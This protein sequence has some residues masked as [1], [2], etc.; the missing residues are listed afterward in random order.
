MGIFTSVDAA[1]VKAKLTER[2]AALWSATQPSSTEHQPFLNAT[3][4]EIVQHI[5][6][7]EWT[8][9]QVLEAYI[10]RAVQAQQETRCLTEVFLERA[11]A[12]AR[13]LDE[14]F[15]TS[16]TLRGPLHGVPV[17][18]KDQLHVAGCDTTLGYTTRIHRPEN[19][20]AVI[21]TLLRNAGAVPFVKTNIPQTLMVFECSNP[22]WGRSLNPWSADHT[23]GGSSGG[24]GA[25]LAMDGSVLGIGSDV[26]GSL[27]IPAH[28]CGIYS[29]KPGNIR[30]SSEGTTSTVPGFTAVTSAY[31]PMGRSVD[32]LETACRVL[33]GH[34][35]GHGAYFPAPVPFR[36]HWQKIPKKLRFG[37]YTS[38]YFIK[39][40]PA[41]KR[42]VLET[43]EALRSQGHECIDFRVPGAVR[44]LELFVALSSSDGYRTVLSDIGPDKRESALYLMTL[45]PRLPSFVR[46]FASW[47]SS[48]IDP[49]FA[50]LLALSRKK[51][52]EEYHQF[53]AAKHDFE[54]DW[55]KEVWDC[56]EFDAV[57]APVQA[58]PALPH[59]GC[60]YLSPLAAAT[61]LYNIVEAPVGCIPVTRVDPDKD[62][63]TD[64]WL[65]AP[66]RGS[67]I[68][69]SRVYGLGG[70]YDPV[71][72][73]GL[74]VGVQIVARP[75]E[76]EK[77]LGIMRLVDN[78][79]GPRG[80][81]PGC[82]KARD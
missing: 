10:A 42:A 38:D 79:L 66:D 32:D 36:D 55:R 68:L 40:S 3:A 46:F 71:K 45:G 62:A 17:S 51:S 15:S 54:Y 69:E 1:A 50:K 76:E 21:A 67:K 8:A 61:I 25:L 72:M 78:A 14:H 58:V 20:D 34:S 7:G 80:F 77:L 4:N 52:V 26:G 18:L 12:E 28:Y 47:F 43:V 60:D 64:E 5:E 70:V 56:H 23:C 30:I 24:E 82:W 44:A 57:I 22:L 65:S 2:D 39:A 49:I 6:K 53:I 81:G 59:H 75:W 29:L 9:S 13:S 74:P 63:V 73:R 41:C 35:Q 11:R 31:G 33:F 27:R 16:K 19:D 48:F 37:Y